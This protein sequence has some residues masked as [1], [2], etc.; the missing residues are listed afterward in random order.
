[1]DIDTDTRYRI[2]TKPGI[3]WFVDRPCE[4]DH[5]CVLMVMVGDDHRW[6]IDE[7]DLIEIDDDEYCG[8]CGQIGCGWG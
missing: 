5:E 4:D 2:K 6:H 8:S 1:V 7:G 3:A